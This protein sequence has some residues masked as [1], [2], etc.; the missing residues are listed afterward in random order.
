MPQTIE[1]VDDGTIIQFVQCFS[2]V[3]PNANKLFQKIERFFIPYK[4]DVISL[5]DLKTFISKQIK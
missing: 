3:F 1:C 2:D 4:D 5:H